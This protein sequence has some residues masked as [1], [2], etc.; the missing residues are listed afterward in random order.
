MM[1]RK[2]I[3]L[4]TSFAD[5]DYEK[6]DFE[7]LSVKRPYIECLHSSGAIPLIVPLQ[8]EEEN[9]YALAEITDGLLLP[10]GDDVHPRHY[11]AENIHKNS[12]PFSR[13]RDEMEITLA[14]IFI[15]CGKPVFGICRG[16]QVLNVALGG[17]LYQDIGAEFGTS[18]R[19]EY[20]TSVSKLDRYTQDVHEVYLLE[21]TALA[22]FFGSENIT[23]N[24]LHHQAV[25]QVAETLRPSA[26]A[27]DGIIEAIES[28]DMNVS[29]I[30]GV[31]WHPETITKEHPEQAV[32]FR[33][34][35]EIAAERNRSN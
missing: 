6:K 24:S 35:T 8:S 32:L 13:E 5:E 20:N 29:W 22:S 26:I 19:H 3:I 30:L 17:T 28:K 9:L 14:K 34:F 11:G 18:I 33:K 25:K 7:C 21:D 27:E 23:T 31:Q 4:T 1:K 12:G 15:A 10:G 16:A 2:P